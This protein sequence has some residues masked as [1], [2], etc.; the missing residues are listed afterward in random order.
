MLNDILIEFKVKLSIT[1]QP[2]AV[3]CFSGAKFDKLLIF[4]IIGHRKGPSTSIPYDFQLVRM[5]VYL[6]YV[7]ATISF[8]FYFIDLKSLNT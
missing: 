7:T 5:T 2:V 4:L 6:M 3:N 8:H 1:L